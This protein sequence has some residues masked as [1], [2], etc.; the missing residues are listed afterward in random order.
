MKLFGRE[1]FTKIDD[2]KHLDSFI[3]ANTGKQSTVT[4]SRS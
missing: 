1:R 4:T 2:I 3:A